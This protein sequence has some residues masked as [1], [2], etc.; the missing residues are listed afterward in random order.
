[1]LF[2]TKKTHCMV[3][4]RMAV[5]ESLYKN[6]EATVGVFKLVRLFHWIEDSEDFDEQ[7]N[8]VQVQVDGR[9]NVFLGGEFVHQHVSVENNESWEQ[10]GT[11]NCIHQLKCLTVEEKLKE[12]HRKSVK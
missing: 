9:Q 12:N 5:K 3:T 6:P 1:M 7:V 8:H 2:S 4:K 10:Q 11:G